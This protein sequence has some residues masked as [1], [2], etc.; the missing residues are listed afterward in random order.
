MKGPCV[1]YGVTSTGARFGGFNS[2]GFK[3]SDDYYASSNAFLFC[4]PASE[5]QPVILRKVPSAWW[6]VTVLLESCMKTRHRPQSP[7][8]LGLL[9]CKGSMLCNVDGAALEE[10]AE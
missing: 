7:S 3:S 8:C 4:W 9:C 10:A 6:L 2:E 1:V 5:D